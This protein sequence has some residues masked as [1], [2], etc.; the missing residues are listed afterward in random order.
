[1]TNPAITHFKW[2][3]EL[4]HYGETSAT[5]FYSADAPLTTTVLEL[6]EHAKLLSVAA[7]LYES[8]VDLLEDAPNVD[9]H[10]ARLDKARSLVATIKGG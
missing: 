4:T 7:E 2:R 3:E 5:V 8:L 6:R 1:M 9:E 10:L